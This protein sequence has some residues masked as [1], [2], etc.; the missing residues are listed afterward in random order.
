MDTFVAPVNFNYSTLVA[1]IQNYL[2]QNNPD[3]IGQIPT[4]IGLAEQTLAV[5]IKNLGQLMNANWTGISEIMDKP[6]GWR[7]TKSLQLLNLSAGAQT[8]PLERS[9][10]FCRQF[11]SE[12][13]PTY[14]ATIGL[15]P[16]WY[17]DYGYDRIILSPYNSTTA[18][19]ITLKLAYYAN[20]PP[21]SELNQ[22]N[23]WTINAP[24][25]IFYASILHALVYLRMDERQQP[26]N[27]M[28]QQAIMAINSEDNNR[29]NDQSYAIKPALQSD[30]LG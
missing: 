15:L 23:Y 7:Q 25:A 26:I 27:A 1:I 8:F 22:N 10:E 19:H 11:S 18:P 13:T 16:Q 30:R 12:C 24:E 28:L 6:V 29:V 5:S 3:F 2:Q 9:Y 17:G 4:F 14:L 21:L 20:P